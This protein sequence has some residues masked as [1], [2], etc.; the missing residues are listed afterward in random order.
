MKLERRISEIR[1][2]TRELLNNER[3]EHKQQVETI[4]KKM[5]NERD[6]YEM[7][8]KSFK[9]DIQA[10][11]DE[12]K[13]LTNEISITKNEIINKISSLHQIEKNL[14]A[15]KR[16]VSL[17]KEAKE[18]EKTRQQE[19]KQ[20]IKDKIDFFV[21]EINKLRQ[22]PDY[23]NSLQSLDLVDLQSKIKDK[24]NEINQLMVENIKCI[25]AKNSLMLISKKIDYQNGQTDTPIYKK[26]RNLNLTPSDIK[27]ELQLVQDENDHLAKYID[28]VL[29]RIMENHSEL[30]EV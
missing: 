26:D 27:V 3:K 19:E 5:L 22:F 25:E 6:N 30:L 10:K 20:S 18:T 8:M 12:Q 17:S 28:Q 7:S 13:N 4:Q 11:L 16:E 2:E 9:Q 14:D 15:T 24:E 21:E 23:C 1:E 29:T